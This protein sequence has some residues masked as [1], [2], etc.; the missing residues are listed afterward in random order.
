MRE[1]LARTGVLFTQLEGDVGHV[2]DF[3][4]STV[5]ALCDALDAAPVD[6]AELLRQERQAH[7]VTLALLS[8]AQA[9]H[10]GALDEVAAEGRRRVAAEDARGV[11]AQLVAEAVPRMQTLNNAMSPGWLKRASALLGE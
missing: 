2:P 8:D 10:A 5:V 3:W 1:A 11:A 6:A 7:A 9:A 4:R